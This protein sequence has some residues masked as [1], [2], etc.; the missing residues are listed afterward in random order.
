MEIDKPQCEVLD[1]V[2][3]VKLMEVKSSDVATF[4]FNGRCFLAKCVEVYDGDTCKLVFYN[5]GEMIK[6]SFRMLG[7]NAPEITKVEQHVKELGLLMRDRLRELILNTI[8]YVECGKFEKY[9]RILARIYGDPTK[10]TSI[11]DEMSQFLTVIE[12]GELMG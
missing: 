9:G 11:N 12:R 1:Q 2:Q 10:K 5:N 7:Y 4:S 6:Y 8:V 3:L